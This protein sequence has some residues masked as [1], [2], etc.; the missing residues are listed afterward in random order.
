MPVTDIIERFEVIFSTT[1]GC[2]G[3]AE[4]E[5]YEDKQPHCKACMHD[6]VDN[7]IPVL[8]RKIG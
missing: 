3:F 1:C 2:G 4:Y 7:D 5:V 6:A 8:V